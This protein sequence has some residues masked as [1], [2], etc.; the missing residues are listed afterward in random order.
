MDFKKCEVHLK[1]VHFTICEVNV[2]PSWDEWSLRAL[3]KFFPNYCYHWKHLIVT[4]N[5]SGGKCRKL[6]FILQNSVVRWLQ[7]I[8]LSWYGECYRQ[9]GIIKLL[10]NRKELE[11]RG[12]GITFPRA[13]TKGTPIYLAFNIGG[14]DVYEN[15]TIKV[16]SSTI[17]K[18]HFNL[19]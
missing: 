7:D 11:K 13:N 12:I 10:Q 5:L 19:H 6:R 16:S 17:S 14:V 8:C 1:N 15:D 2:L 18:Q 9:T 4:T 3:S